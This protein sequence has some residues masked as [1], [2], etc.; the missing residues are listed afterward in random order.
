MFTR[1]LNKAKFKSQIC[2]K[3]IFASAITFGILNNLIVKSQP[4]FISNFN[5]I[6]RKSS[7]SFVT[8]AVEKTGASVVTID[9]EKIVKQSKFPGNSRILIDPYFERFFPFK[10]PH[11]NIPEIQQGQGSGFIFMDGLWT[12]AHVVNGSDKVIVGRLMVKN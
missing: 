4:S 10:L 8:Q 2:K 3:I 7:G 11:E 9:T 1:Y 12:N 5:P 6:T